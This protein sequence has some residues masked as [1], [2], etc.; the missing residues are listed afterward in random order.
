MD[1]I[2]TFDCYGTLIDT[3]P[4]FDAISN[5]AKNN[6][7]NSKDAVNIYVNY[8]DRLMYG[9]TYIP[10]DK[11]IKQVLEYCD[12]E[13][14][15]N[16]FSKSYDEIISVHKRLKP[17]KEVVESLEKIHKKGYELALMSNSVHDIIDYNLDALGNVFN[18]VFLSED[19]HAYK[20]QLKFFKYVEERLELKQKKHCH[21]A[22][23]YWWDIVPCSKLGWRKIWVNRENKK[24]NKCHEPYEEVHTLDEVIN[25]I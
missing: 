7:L 11:L 22:K 15:T 9:E 19:I 10:Y 24:G 1:R 13:L 8:E 25:L 20:P 5:I 12:M 23:G 17:F 21:I 4:V 3:K 6:I 18:N 14:V 2:L 16:V